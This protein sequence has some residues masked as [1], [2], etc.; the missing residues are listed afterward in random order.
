MIRRSLP[1]GAV[2]LLLAF[3]VSGSAQVGATATVPAGP[4]AAAKKPKVDTLHGE[5]RVDNYFWLREKTNPEVIKYLEAENAWT[6]AGMKHTEGLQDTLY[7]EMLGRIKE[8]DLS[9]PYREGGYWYYSRTEQG[10]SYQILCRKKGTLEAPEEIML[11][12]NALAAGKKFYALGGVSVSPDGNLLLYLADTTA[13]RD[14]TLYVKDLRTG[15]LLPDVLDKVWNGL[16]WA[17]DNRTFFY[18]TPDSAKRG[19]AVWRHALGQ[20]RSAD[21]KVFQEDNVLNNVSVFRSKSGKYVFIPADGFTSS[22]WRVIPTANPTAP[23]RILAARRPGVEYSVVHID[24][25]FLIHTNDGATNFRIV[26]TPETDASPAAWRDWLPASDSVFIEF[27]DVTR[28]YTVVA[29]RA[30]GLRRLRVVDNQ[31]GA[32]HFITFPEA[33]YAVFPSSNEDYDATTYRF[34][35]ASFTT[36]SSVYDYDLTKRTR[37]LK[38]RQEIPSGFDPARYEVR[39]FMVT[40]RD[41]VRVPV[42]MLLPRGF[43][44]DGSRPFLLYAYGSYGATTEPGFNSNVL[45]LVNR[46]FGYAI[47]HVRGG[48][49]MGRKWYDDGKMLNKKNT[50]HDFI[51]VA[52]HLVKERYTSPGK[53]VA[54]GGSAGGLLMGAI[55]NLRPELFRAI[56]ADVPFVDVINTMLDASLPLTA[57]EWEQWGNPRIAEHYAY[58]KSYSPYDNVAAKDYPWLLVTTSLN[59]SQVMYFEPAKW[60]ARLRSTK[61]DQNPLY[62]K[63]NMGGGHGGSSG[64]YDRLK[65]IAYRYAFMID[66]TREGG[67]AVMP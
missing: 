57:Q 55:A 64:R 60:V 36:P 8:T 11:D 5:V 62:F 41:G 16:A 27:L 6:A 47:A 22:E 42:S 30:A 35:Y 63:T 48:Q 12:V 54:N 25:A 56:V 14:Y 7:R 19:N 18:M 10:K 24:G 44:Q 58:M 23:P 9:V 38:K 39:R 45:S 21:V 20:P 29:E 65:E 13:F 49:E 32:S 26:K 17:E 66:A 33:A 51:D 52:D 40:A 43:A 50:F 1:L 61:T 34:S 4:P 31:S 59:D 67:R 46:G 28:R 37:E 53:L 2:A 15:T 3:P